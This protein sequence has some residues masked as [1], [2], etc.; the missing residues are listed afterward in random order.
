MNGSAKRKVRVVEGI[1]KGWKGRVLVGPGMS[2]EFSMNICSRQVSS[3]SALMLIL[4]MELV[5]RRV[6]K[7]GILERMLYAH[8][9][10]VVVESRREKQEV[11][12]EW[13]RN[14][15]DKS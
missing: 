10:A 12:V 9:Q 4:V 3:L 8:D 2:E 15:R 6:N 5:S 7:K 1:Y 14:L 11:L 13:K